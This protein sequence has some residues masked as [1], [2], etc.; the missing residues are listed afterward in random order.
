MKTD[1]TEKILN[2][3]L[4]LFIERGLERTPMAKIADRAK[5]GMGTI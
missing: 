3:T 2:A 4:T 5:V 1:K